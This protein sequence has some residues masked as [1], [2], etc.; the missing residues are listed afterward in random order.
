MQI[1]QAPKNPEGI[2]SSRAGPR[3]LYP[4]V[5]CGATD[6]G[7]LDPLKKLLHP[8]SCLLGTSG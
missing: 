8:E 6:V 2:L 7:H 3:N 1:Y 4:A 5:G